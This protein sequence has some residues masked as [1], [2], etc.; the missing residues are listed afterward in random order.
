MSLI[1]KFRNDIA[2]FEQE[3][4]MNDFVK[5]TKLLIAK[6]SACFPHHVLIND[7]CTPSE[8]TRKIRYLFEKS[9]VDLYDRYFQQS[10]N[11][12]SR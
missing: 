6:G 9:I 12:L 11:P 10:N 2:D 5:R 8:I 4:L 7:Y 1:D 3:E